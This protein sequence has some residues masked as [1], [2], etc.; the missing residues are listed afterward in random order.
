MNLPLIY[1]IQ[2]YSTHDGEGIRTTVFFKG[3]PLRCKWC[4]S[5]EGQRSARELLFYKEHCVN[6]RQCEEYCPQ[7]A[8]T[9]DGEIKVDPGRCVGCGICSANCLYGARE[10]AGKEYKVD[11]LVNML[12]KDIEF[13]EES[14]GGVTLSG[15][16]V[17]AQ[18]I[19]YIEKLV[20]ALYSEH[21]NIAID[22][23]GYAEY[24]K[25]RRLLP[26]VNTFLYDIK[27]MDTEKHKELTGVD[28][29]HILHN[30]IRLSRDKAGIV[31]RLPL[32]HTVNDTR[33]DL[34]QLIYFL[35]RYKV[36]YQEIQLLPYHDVGKELYAR[37]GRTYCGNE[38]TAPG[39]QYISHIKQLFSINGIRNVVVAT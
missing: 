6:C 37:I 5:P 4:H 17:M 35:K 39:E 14:N 3:C 8:I 24:E 33:E 22:T 27:V 9:F 23:C 2:K 19:D 16:E 11:D 10:L 29:T 31:L 26:Y 20:Q 21:F 28:N 38:Y 34:L 18:D 1:D 32:I 25:F 36:H 15:G 13:Y 30:L 12:A 7:E